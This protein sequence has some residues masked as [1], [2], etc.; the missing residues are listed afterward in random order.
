MWN[1]IP[2]ESSSWFLL[3]N[4]HYYYIIVVVVIVGSK[5]TNKQIYIQGVLFYIG[6][7]VY[8]LYRCGMK[9]LFAGHVWV[10]I[11]GLMQPP[12]RGP[13][14][15]SKL[16]TL[17]GVKCD[18]IWKALGTSLQLCIT[19]VAN[20]CNVFSYLVKRLPWLYKRRASARGVSISRE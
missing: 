17:I 18:L 5:T 1:S 6:H 19:V 10:Y 11:W 13:F 20:L 15:R 4:N 16:H 3:W 12:M 9:M 8:F 2:S 14:N 7:S